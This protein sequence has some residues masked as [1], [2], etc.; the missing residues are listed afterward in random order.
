MATAGTTVRGAIDPLRALAEV[1]RER[2]LWLHVDGAIGAVFGLCDSTASLLDGIAA[3]D[4]I[5]VNPQKLLGIAKTSSLLLVRDQTALQ[6]TFH[7]GLPY[8]EPALTGVHGGELGLQG[9]RPAEIL[10]LW[11]GLRQLGED[12]ITSVLQQAWPGAIACRVLTRP[13]STSSLDRCICWPAHPAVLIRSA[14]RWS[15]SMRQNL[16]DQQIL[17]LAS[18]ASRSSPH[19]S[20]AGESP[21][22]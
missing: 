13:G 11:L 3:A 4:S 21:H 9:S 17:G 7:T 6:E 19:Q 14:A 15:A 12:G 8:M 1:C 20:C 22:V 18:T 2:S 5:T 10:K 16:L